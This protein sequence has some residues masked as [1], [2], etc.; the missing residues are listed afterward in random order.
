MSLS[1]PERTERQWGADDRTEPL[2]L[3]APPASDRQIGTNR[4]AIW[5]TVV[6]WVAYTLRAMKAQL[7]DQ[8]AT[9]RTVLDMLLY[10]MVVSALTGSAVAYLV[11]RHGFLTRSQRHSRAPRATLDEQFAVASPSLVVLVPSYREE[12]RVV[13]Q[14]LLSAALQEYDNI[15]IVL[16]IDDPARAKDDDSRRLLE[17]ALALPEE[18]EA[19]LAGPAAAARASL[20]GFDNR[21]GRDD[22]AR[23]SA[24]SLPSSAPSPM[25]C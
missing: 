2:P 22:L 25:P 3:T 16:L 24:V 19:L 12:S 4:A 5:V 17:Q 9:T 7:V 8:P 14:T 11:A 20:A 10:F 6:A 13:R 1:L 18:V 23:S 15:R 21:R